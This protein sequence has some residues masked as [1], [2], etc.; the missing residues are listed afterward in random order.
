MEKQELIAE[1]NLALAKEFEVD[2]SV[3]S[4]E[5]NIR[6]AL[7]LDSLSLVDLVALLEAHFKIKITGAEM[8]QLLTF[9]ALYDFVYDKVK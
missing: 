8:S 9:Q 6:E 1:I 5:A 3:I 7:Q 2:E 4:P